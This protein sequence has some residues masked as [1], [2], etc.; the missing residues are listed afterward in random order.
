MN[1]VDFLIKNIAA[2]MNELPKLF[3][4]MGA[5]FPM[6]DAAAENESFL[7]DMVANELNVEDLAYSK[8]PSKDVE[9][10]ITQAKI[11][12]DKAIQKLL[13]EHEGASI[14]AKD[15]E[16]LYGKWTLAQSPD[17]ENGVVKIKLIYTSAIKLAKTK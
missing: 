7:I 11:N 15:L 2:S 1:T 17:W 12:A 5:S 13:D 8:T 6:V 4:K 3:S 10:L 14:V 9:A 16:S